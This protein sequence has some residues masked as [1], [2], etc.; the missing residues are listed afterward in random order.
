[1]NTCSTC[2]AWGIIF[3]RPGIP[4]LVTTC[5]DCRGIGGTVRFV[6]M[7]RELATLAH[8]GQYR[9]DKH[10]TPTNEAYIHH[11]KR[12]AERFDVWPA[13]QATAWLHDAMEDHPDKVNRVVME[14][15][16]I[17]QDVITAV[18]AITKGKGED[19]VNYL[20]EVKA[21]RIARAVKIRDVIDNLASDPTDRQIEKYSHALEFL[22]R[23][24]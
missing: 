11:C 24:D 23:E 21:N 5:P 13:A 2:N 16:N 8:S 7:A 18:E 15:A 9:R 12:I 17:P 14:A 10:G 6:D 22:V 20:Q 4:N 19:Y 1:M 3:V